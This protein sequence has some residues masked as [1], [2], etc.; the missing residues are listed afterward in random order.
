MDQTPQLANVSERAKWKSGG[1]KRRKEKSEAMQPKKKFRDES[2]RKLFRDE[3]H[4]A[5]EEYVANV[6]EEMT[7]CKMRM[8]L[9]GGR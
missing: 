7:D 2:R 9:R 4:G 8:N 6:K 1:D 5:R 3:Q